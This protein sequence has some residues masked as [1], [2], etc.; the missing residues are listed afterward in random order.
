MTFKNAMVVFKKELKDF[1]RDKRTIITSIIVPLLLF[2]LIYS[3]IG[4]QI[5]ST[6]EKVSKAITIG[7]AKNTSDETIISL[8]NNI[9]SGQK[10]EFTLVK[11]DD[12]QKAIEDETIDLGMQFDDRSVLVALKA[13][14][15]FELKIIY[16]DNKIVSGNAVSVAQSAIEVYNTKTANAKLKALGLAEQDIKPAQMSFTTINEY[17]VSI[18]GTP[19]STGQTNSFLAMILP[20]LIGMM[21]PLGTVA[22]ATDLFAGE[23]ERGTLEPLLSTKAGR[24]SVLLGKYFA[25][26]V[27]G[28]ISITAY[29][30]GFLIAVAM[31]PSLTSGFSGGGSTSAFSGLS[32]SLGVGVMVI[33]LIVLLSMTA[34]ALQVILSTWSKSVK[35]AGSYMSFMTIAVM[36]PAYATMMLQPGDVKEY[37][38]LIPL[39]NVIASIKLALAGI[40]DV[41]LYA[42][43]ILSSLV[44]LVVILVLVLK[45][46][47]KESVL[48][49]N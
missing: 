22:A 24:A 8:K 29:I 43:A 49:R 9:F 5:T 26:I 4:G 19:A 35:E 20:L 42:I 14:T 34:T 28:L 39:Y 6:V 17:I 18:G 23:K 44:V 36:V 16:D 33:F 11:V 37:M 27:L 2:P 41:K 46:L 30:S 40:N 15:P 3:V 1:F 31:N 25:V 32:I 21:V 48:F 47:K 45:M 7:V 12:F 10:T 13:T 38:M